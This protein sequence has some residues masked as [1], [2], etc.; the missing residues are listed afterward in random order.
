MD[1]VAL[2][3]FLEEMGV[4]LVSR[5]PNAAGYLVCKCPL[6]GFLHE[7]GIDAHPSFFVKVDPSGVSGFHCFTCKEKGRLSSLVRKLGFHRGENLS[8]L[9]IRVDMAE[10]PTEFASFG[11]SEAD[12]IQAPKELSEAV[13]MAM[14]PEAWADAEARSYLASRGIGAIAAGTIGLRFDPDERRVL[15]PVRDRA[16]K[17]FGFSGRAI[18]RDVDPR[19]RDYHFKK[20]RFL[21]GAH[22]I[23]PGKPM[24]LVEGLFAFA[25][26]VEVGARRFVNP[27]APMMSNVSEYQVNSLAAIG[28]PTYICFDDDL[29]GD[30]GVFGKVD[31][32]GGY[33]GGGA[34]DKLKKHIPVMVPPR[35]WATLMLSP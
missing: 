29:A 32:K 19:H 21:L 11:S 28:E 6:A 25:R 4:E 24:W 12:T 33:L 5:K 23:Q 30:Q 31:G 26:M 15:F 7:R 34:A 2:L 20:E 14:F 35:G 16:C 10:T 8:S 18:D 13:H 17:L 3:G 1:R 27:V 9:A 22:L